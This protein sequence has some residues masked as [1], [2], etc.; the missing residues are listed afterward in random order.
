[1]VIKLRKELAYLRSGTAAADYNSHGRGAL[2]SIDEEGS[3]GLR[4][5]L[6]EL[7]GKYAK[8][9]ADLS[10]AQS[11]ERPA[12]PGGT[13]AL[14]QSDFEGLIQ[15]VVEE[16]EKSITALES[17]LA[18]LK[19][20]LVH[21]EESMREQE[22][23]LDFEQQVNETNAGVIGDL[24]SRVA[25][26]AEREALTETYV[27]DL[28]AK[29]K[30]MTDQDETSN[31]LLSELKKEVAKYREGEG[32]S[33]RYI[34]DLE[35]RLAQSDE[36]NVSLRSQIEALERDVQR[37]EEAYKDLEGR[38]ALLDTS[39]QQKLLLEELDEKQKRVL[40]LER[41]Y[42]SL[43]TLATATDLCRLQVRSISRNSRKRHS[44]AN[45]NGWR[46]KPRVTS[47]L[48]RRSKR[49]FGILRSAT[50]QLLPRQGSWRQRAVTRLVR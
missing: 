44:I 7:Q 43:D 21:S 50:L 39:D 42:R 46:M 4:A 32:R 23:K 29:L 18:L 14:S 47:L 40:E 9:L 28:E 13:P 26:L 48:R 38:A 16:Y 36:A 8:A 49:R 19:A 27:R 2:S 31:G 45:G 6:A 15:P 37:R 3:L 1:M 11:T 17:Q 12:S 22:E 35:A 34:K 10:V 5:D 30:G 33:E 20:A 25:K 24:K 41:A